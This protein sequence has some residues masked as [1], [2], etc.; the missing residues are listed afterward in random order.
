MLR[1]EPQPGFLIRIMAALA[2]AVNPKSDCNQAKNAGRDVR[3]ELQSGCWVMLNDAAE[4]GYPADRKSSLRRRMESERK[5][6]CMSL[7]SK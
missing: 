7:L 4:L 3:E 1:L 2:E 6:K 5:W